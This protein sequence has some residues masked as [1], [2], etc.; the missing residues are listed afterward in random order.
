MAGNVIG[1]RLY[2]SRPPTGFP[3]LQD[4]FDTLE[5]AQEA[6]DLWNQYA[7]WHKAQRKK[8]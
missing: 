1:P 2:G 8:K 7:L 4:L 3:P 6:C 5:A